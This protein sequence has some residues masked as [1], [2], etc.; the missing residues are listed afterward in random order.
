MTQKV[1]ITLIPVNL[2]AEEWLGFLFG[3][4]EDSFVIRKYEW[5]SSG[6]HRRKIIGA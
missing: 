2:L 4:S 3:K 1:G 6:L 5:F